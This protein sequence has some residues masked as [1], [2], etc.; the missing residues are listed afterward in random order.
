VQNQ[1]FQVDLRYIILSVE[2]PVAGKSS[3]VFVIFFDLVFR[4]L[5]FG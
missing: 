4:C 5:P 3:S 2:M 1:L